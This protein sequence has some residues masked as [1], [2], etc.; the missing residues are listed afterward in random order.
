M[1]LHPLLLNLQ[2]LSVQSLHLLKLVR[3]SLL[4]LIRSASTRVQDKAKKGVQRKIFHL[5][6][7]HL[8]VE[9]MSPWS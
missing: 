7:C 3:S 5:Y 9:R 1:L 6:Q 4:Q 2:L 8:I